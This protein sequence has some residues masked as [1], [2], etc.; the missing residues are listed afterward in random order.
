MSRYIEELWNRNLNKGRRYVSDPSEAPDDVNVQQG[1]Q[2]GYYYETGG[3]S[4]SDVP[5]DA[6]GEGDRLAGE[7]ALQDAGVPFDNETDGFTAAIGASEGMNDADLDAMRDAGYAPDSID[8]SQGRVDASFSEETTTDPQEQEVDMES[9]ELAISEYPFDYERGG[10]IV[11]QGQHV[12]GI[13]DEALEGMRQA[14]FKVDSITP[15]GLVRF[16][17]AGN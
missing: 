14:G 8:T 1:E 6:E 5:N 12:D 3:A 16:G 13:D 17:Q 9:A 15:D 11:V 10:N 2:G 7:T 4:D